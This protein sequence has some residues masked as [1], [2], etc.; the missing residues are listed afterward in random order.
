MDTFSGD[1]SFREM[2]D[3]GIDDI[4]EI[5]Q[6]DFYEL[7]SKVVVGSPSPEIKHANHTNRTNLKQQLM[8]QQVA[9]Q[10]RKESFS[11][12][13]M[14]IYI[15]PSDSINVPEPKN[16]GKEV[17][18]QVL[19]VKT[20]LEHPTKY[21][22]QQKQNQQIQLF[23]HEKQVSGST[24]VPG[25]TQSMPNMVALQGTNITDQSDVLHTASAPLTNPDSP[26]PLPAVAN[27]APT[28]MDNIFPE[29]ISLESVDATIDNDLN[30]IEPTLTQLTSTL[31]QTSV[32]N[33]Y[34]Q[35]T[36]NS[37]SITSVP[38][39]F[40][41]KAA[42]PPQFLNEDEARQWAKDRQKKDNHNLIERRR[43]F[44]INDRIKELGTLLPK[45]S[46]PDTRQNKG[47]ILKNSVD[48]IRKLRK[49]QDKMHNLEEKNRL[50]E[51]N[52]RKLMLRVQHLEML[53]KSHGISTGLP[54]DS[55]SLAVFADLL[56]PPCGKS[57]TDLI[58]EQVNN[59]F[60]SVGSSAMDEDSSPVSGDP[61]MSSNPVSPSMDEDDDELM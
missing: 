10:E 42:D 36:E 2:Q 31:P 22:I 57:D 48:Y 8:K 50:S 1:S 40:R 52:N 45:N 49:D 21:H 37:K 55:S 38:N 32:L 51:T 14:K 56:T 3:S 16:V 60:S 11:P 7:K 18:P 13:S 34:D 35:H 58:M 61:M 20:Q 33:L 5:L 41:L 9:E 53:C 54:N 47:S 25:N 44:N 26:L 59:G 23:L 24:S 4:W 46:D 6:D 15:D 19:Q 17:P 43:R 29:G 27:P 28:D 39:A 30:L 12:E